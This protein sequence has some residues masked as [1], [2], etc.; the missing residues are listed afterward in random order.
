MNKCYKCGNLLV[1]STCDHCGSVYDVETI[2][3]YNN[4]K[5]IKNTRRYLIENSSV[6]EFSEAWKYYY[7]FDCAG[8]HTLQAYVNT[9][10]KHKMQVK[11][12]LRA[13]DD[14]ELTL[15]KDKEV[16]LLAR[17][18]SGKLS[19]VSNRILKKLGYQYAEDQEAV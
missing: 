9:I 13:F 6:Q 2:Y 4:H 3:A 11:E 14:E 10:K 15:M 16:T 8:S 7:D 1:S 17:E 19:D 5:S 12:F 18:G